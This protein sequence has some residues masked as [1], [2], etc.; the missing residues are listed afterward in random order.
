MMSI[1]EQAVEH[2]VSQNCE[3]AKTSTRT[4]DVTK[5]VSLLIFLNWYSTSTHAGVAKDTK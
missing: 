3:Q 5:Y 2:G 1:G 4:P